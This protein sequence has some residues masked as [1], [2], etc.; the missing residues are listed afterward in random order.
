MIEYGDIF[1][2]LVLSKRLY[3]ELDVSDLNDA[4]EDSD[5]NNWW[6]LMEAGD[7]W[8]IISTYDLNNTR[9][10]DRYPTY[11]FEELLNMSG[12]SFKYYADILDSQIPVEGSA[13]NVLAKIILGDYDKLS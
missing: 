1:T 4:G 10:I 2:N 9:S 12:I 8:F 13:V 3:E 5:V 7:E 6:N 11:T